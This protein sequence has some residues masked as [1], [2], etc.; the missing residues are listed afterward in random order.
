MRFQGRDEHSA[1]LF[2]SHAARVSTTAASEPSL[3]TLS[4]PLQLEADTCFGVY[5]AVVE[6]VALDALVQIRTNFARNQAIRC[7]EVYCHKVEQNTH[8]SGSLMMID[9][10]GLPAV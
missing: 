6:Q 10:S 5:R 8:P 3:A 4:F 9:A 1:Q 2:P 7:E